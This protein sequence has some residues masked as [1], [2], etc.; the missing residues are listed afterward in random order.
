M[1]SFAIDVAEVL[2]LQSR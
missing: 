1:F 2:C